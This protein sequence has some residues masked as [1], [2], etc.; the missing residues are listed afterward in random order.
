M[1]DRTKLGPDTGPNGA[2]KL[3]WRDTNGVDT[4]KAPADETDVSPNQ[5]R[6][7]GSTVPGARRRRGM[8]R[9][10]AV[11]EGSNGDGTAPDQRTPDDA[12]RSGENRGTNIPDTTEPASP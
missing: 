9:K 3:N 4:T 10:D 6:T 1:T 7:E 8:P 2:G 11:D 5:D 12:E